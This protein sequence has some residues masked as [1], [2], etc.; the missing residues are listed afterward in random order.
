[1]VI[2]VRRSVVKPNGEKLCHRKRQ[3]LRRRI[4]SVDFPLMYS[5]AMDLAIRV[6]SAIP[7]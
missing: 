3:L 4:R 5:S 7:C 1:M 2:K 6:C